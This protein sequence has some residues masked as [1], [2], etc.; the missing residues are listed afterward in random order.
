MY[1]DEMKEEWFTMVTEMM[2][3]EGWEGPVL[4][5]VDVGHTDPICTVP[6]GAKV[7]L[8]VDVER[9]TSVWEVLERSVV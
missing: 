6:L 7:K 4:A 8:E 2:D 5:E 3:A 1:T 9:E